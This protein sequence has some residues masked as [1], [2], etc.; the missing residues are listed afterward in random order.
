[1]SGSHLCF[2]RNE[3]VISKQN[4]NV[5]SPSSYTHI[6]GR[7][8]YVHFQDRSTYSAA[9]KYV[10]QSWEYINLSQTHECEAVQFPEKK[11]INGIFLAVLAI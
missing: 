9:G 8:L 2:P 6:S 7:D 5:L 11:Q 1:M 4:Y 10:D 3:T